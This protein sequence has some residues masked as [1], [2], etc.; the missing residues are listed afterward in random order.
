MDI[1][2]EKSD[3]KGTCNAFKTLGFQADEV[4]TIWR[5]IASILHLGNVEFQS[6]LTL[7]TPTRMMNT[8][9]CFFYCNRS[10]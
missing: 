10:H 8:N 3:Y 2:T 4:Q 7:G 6:E 9:L 1:L 5:T